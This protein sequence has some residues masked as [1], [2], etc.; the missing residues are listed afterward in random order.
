MN[1]SIMIGGRPGC[2]KNTKKGTSIHL[3]G[4]RVQGRFSKRSETIWSPKGRM[5]TT[6]DE[7]GLRVLSREPKRANGSR[8]HGGLQEVRGAH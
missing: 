4:V 5:G 3:V 6:Q 7:E 2:Y 1:P 8:E